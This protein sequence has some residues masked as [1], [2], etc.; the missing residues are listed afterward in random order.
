MIPLVWQL[1][2]A[3]ALDFLL[4][5]PRWLP[6]PVRVMGRTALALEAPA[7]RFFRNERI[8]GITAA[9][10]VILGTLLVSWGIL[11]AA[12]SI[13]PLAGDLVSV[14]MMY[15]AV[16][17]KDLG[18]HSRRVLGAL[19]AGDLSGA[20]TA[21]SY[22]VGRDTENLDETGIIRAT[23]ESVAENT[24]DGVLAPLFFAALFGPVGALTFKAVSTLDSTFGYKNKR[25]R[26]FGWAS[27][28]LDDIANFIPARFG[29]ICISIGAAFSGNHP[30]KALAIGLRDARKHASPNAGFPEAAFAGALGIQLGGPVFRAGVSAEA[31]LLGKTG[32]PLDQDHIVKA[33]ILMAAAVVTAA[34]LLTLARGFLEKI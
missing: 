10:A 29:L 9:M 5:D 27:A 24:V 15:T 30:G 32:A 2:I 11:W 31:P 14:W 20:R 3:L 12:G 7:R 4:G 28:R 13:S 17:A 22:I 34:L 6:H 21:V 25:Y 16:A 8:A 1:W 33:N 26:R 18:M 19:D 23:V